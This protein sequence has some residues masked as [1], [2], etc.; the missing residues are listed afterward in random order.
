MDLDNFR[1]ILDSAS[2]DVWTLID[3]ALTVASVDYAD[4]FKRRRDGIAER[5]YKS[6]SASS[7]C[8]NGVQNNNTKIE[9]LLEEELNPHGVLFDDENKNKNNNILEIKKQLECPNQSEDTLVELLHNLDHIDI[10]YEAL[11]GTDIG[12]H[13]N[14]LRK[15]SSNDVRRLVKLLIRFWKHSMILF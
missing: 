2:V 10:T 1:S 9:K 7:P 3:A 5:L 14:K 13:V 4:E 12:R 15:H 6:A 11:E 8:R